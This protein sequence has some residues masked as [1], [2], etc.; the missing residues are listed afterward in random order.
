MIQLQVLRIVVAS[1][2]DVLAERNALED[3]AEELLDLAAARL[4]EPVAPEEE[5]R[6]EAAE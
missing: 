3:V 4:R 5:Q 1:P 2:S 6:N